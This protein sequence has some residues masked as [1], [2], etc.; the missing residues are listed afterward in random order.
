SVPVVAIYLIF[1]LC[2]ALSGK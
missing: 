2:K 1:I